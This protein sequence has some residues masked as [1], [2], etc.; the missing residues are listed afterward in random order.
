MKYT[1]TSKNKIELNLKE[2]K[3]D[4]VTVDYIIGRLC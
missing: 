2:T 3:K 4:M 1:H